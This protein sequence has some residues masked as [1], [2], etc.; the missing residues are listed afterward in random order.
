[1]KQ[2]MMSW[3]Q[4]WGPKVKFKMLMGGQDASIW[5]IHLFL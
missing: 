1:M 2:N 3:N 4:K 5:K